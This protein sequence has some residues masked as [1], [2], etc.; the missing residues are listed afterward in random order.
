MINPFA[1]IHWNPS[2]AERRI[3]GLRLLIGFPIIAAALSLIAWSK[4]GAFPAWPFWIGGIGVS[5]GLLCVLAPW[6][7]RPLYVAWHALG[8]GV[9]FIIGNVTLAAIFVLAVVPTGL[10]LRVLG[11]DPLARRFD[12]GAR[13]YWRDA[14]RSVEAGRYFRQS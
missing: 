8:A 4:S 9:A 10:L 11:K 3:F 7:A 1:D 13:T 5:A 2:A 14:E 12:R 6:V